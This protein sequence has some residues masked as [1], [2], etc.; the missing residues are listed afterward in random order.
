MIMYVYWSF[1]K[2][3][4]FVSDITLNFLDRFLKSTQMSLF[5][6]I[7]SVGAELVSADGQT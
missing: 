4:L 7:H 5:M 2:Y 1:I 3:P 6:K